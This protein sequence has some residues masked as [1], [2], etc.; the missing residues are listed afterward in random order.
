MEIIVE[1]QKP[2]ELKKPAAAAAPPEP[3]PAGQGQPEPKTPTPEEVVQNAKDVYAAMG[4]SDPKEPA[5][6][7]RTAS[8]EPEPEPEPQPEPKAA[9]KPEPEPQQPP[10]KPEPTTAQIIARAARETA[11][12]VAAAIRPQVQPSKPEPEPEPEPE[13]TDADRDDAEVLRYLER[14]DP[15]NY[16]GKREEFI[17][18]TTKHYAY[19]QEWLKNNPD[20]DFDPNDEEHEKWYAENTP[21]IDTDSLDKARVDMRVEEKFEERERPRREA[22]AAQAAFEKKLPELGQTVDRHVIALVNGVDPKLGENLKDAEGKPSLNKEAVAKL[23]Q[24]DPIAKAILDRVASDELEPVILELEKTAI[25]ELKFRLDPQRFPLH[26]VITDFVGQQ[27]RNLMDGPADARDMDGKQFLTVNEY[28]ARAN[29]ARGNQRVLADL[30]ANY[31][32]LSLDMVEEL[33]TDRCAKVARARIADEDQR[34]QKKYGPAKTAG[35]KPAPQPT[36]KPTPPGPMPAGFKPRPPVMKGQADVVATKV[37]GATAP[38]SYGQEAAA[39]H[40]K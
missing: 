31:W 21:N 34:A 15:K 7:A 38:K 24:A 32:T 12:A 19:Q 5:T 22:A 2:I 39:V 23:D 37:P 10:A 18:Y 40:F 27:E 3:P 4:W 11:S 28:A 14:T 9:A 8:P 16:A 36:P 25:P 6:E 1:R 29:E 13:L 33:W 35:A 20:K 17:G 26:K 30:D